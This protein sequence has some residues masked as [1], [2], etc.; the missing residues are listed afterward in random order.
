MSR[1]LSLPF[2]DCEY[3]LSDMDSAKTK[4][5]S[6]FMEAKVRYMLWYRTGVM[7]MGN[8]SAANGFL[9]QWEII[10]GTLISGSWRI[11]RGRLR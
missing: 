6:D 4:A 10:P 9:Q 1:W 3:P 8:T 7:D 11:A 2:F 5:M